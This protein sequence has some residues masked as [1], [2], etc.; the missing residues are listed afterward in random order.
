MKYISLVLVSLCL[1]SCQNFK[2]KE[3]L[4]TAPPAATKDFQQAKKFFKKRQY[5]SAEKTLAKILKSYRATAVGDDSLFLLAK[6]YTRQENWQK[7][8]NVYKNVYESPIYSPREFQARVSAAKLLTYKLKEHKKSLSLIGRS[9]KM[10]PNRVQRAELLEVRFDALMKTG[11]QLEAFETL[12]E[13]SSKHPIQSKRNV[14]KRKA[15]AFLDSRLSGP[16]LKDF[17]DDSSPSQ[18]K[19]DAMYRYGV[20]LFENGQYS[21]AE[22]YLEG[23]IEQ[24]PRS[25][26]SEQS[27]ILLKQMK[28][29]GTVNSRTVG[30][31]LPLSGR[32]SKIGYQT[33][34][35]IQLALGVKGGIS[36]NNLR[37]AVV[38]SQGK[39]EY[40]RRGIKRLVEENQV[41]SVIGGL[42]SKTAYA[43]SIQ[44]QELGVPFIALSQKEGLTDIGPFIF[45]NALT[46]ESQVQT[47]VKTV[48]NDLKRKRFAILYPND[49]Y[50][51]KL[52]NSFWKI[53]KENGGV[54][55]AAQS[56]LPGET[57]F[58]ES[59]QKLVG[60][61]YLEDR[62][63]EYEKRLKEWY[64]EQG[65]NRRRKPPVGLLPPIVDFDALFIPDGP[66]AIGQ[67]APM[68]AYNDI[69][70]VYLIGTNIWNSKEFLRRGQNFVSQS[71]FTDSL[72]TGD[73]KYRNSAFFKKYKETYKRSP[74]S[75]ALQGYDS[76]LIVRSVL[77]RD[78]QSRLD[79]VNEMKRNHGI[80]GALNTLNLNKH[81]EFVRPV[82]TL[83]VKEGE[84]TPFT[85]Q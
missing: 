5:K 76:G 78:V 75:F 38:D 7:A 65:K 33:L 18:L 82:V 60:T 70:N 39:P 2:K 17:A 51:V 3:R 43:A 58:K 61:F 30:V 47:L 24:N 4:A 10:R 34:W 84:I 57:D 41:I 31:V 13:L 42:L 8:F 21:E 22:S 26:V 12:V 6:V 40:A 55:T 74:S 15:K 83:T 81:K 85:T 56:Y 28:T 35:G 25:Y 45:R 32:Y 53:V 67:I 37:L 16:E 36:K 20:Y 63:K 19:T 71:L 54:V 66:K 73:E 1:I 23:V 9:L 27:R 79:F 64:E 48:V 68:L 50:G 14:F 77:S 44:A 46:V 29:R 80:P 52:S 11:S 59:I 62:Q 69:K 49:S 72:N